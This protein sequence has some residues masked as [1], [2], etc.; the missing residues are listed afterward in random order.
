MASAFLKRK[1]WYLQYIDENGKRR[2]AASKAQTKREAR[3]LAD[4]LEIAYER[5]RFGLAPAR[6]PASKE[7]LAE[8]ATWW[9][10]TYAA[11]T[12]SHAID[13]SVVNKHLVGSRFG[14]TKVHLVTPSLVENFLQKKAGVLSPRSINHLRGYLSRIFNAAAKAGRY[15]GANPTK[16]VAKRR[17]AKALPNFLREHEVRPVL[18]AVPDKWRPLFAVAVYT[19]LRKGEI[20][21]L[22]KRDVDLEERQLMVARSYK[23]ETTKGGHADVIPLAQ[24]VVPYFAEA[25]R[26]S[27]STLVFPDE[28]GAMLSR[29]APLEEVLRRALKHA[30]LVEGYE[31]RCRKPGCGHKEQ[32]DDAGLRRCPEHDIKLW[33]VAEVR[34]IRFHDLRHTTA[35][36]LMMRGAN[37]AAVQRILRHSDPKITTEVYGHLVP[38]FMRSEIDRLTFEGPAVAV[39]DEVRVQQTLAALGWFTTR[40]LPDGRDEAVAAMGGDQN[41]IENSGDKMVGAKGF[42]PSASWSRTKRSTKLSYTPCYKRS[43]RLPQTRAPVNGDQ[44][45]STRGLSRKMRAAKRAYVVPL[46]RASGCWPS[47][48]MKRPPT[49]TSRSARLSLENIRVDRR[50][51]SSAPTTLGSCKSRVMKSAHLPARSSPVSTPRAAAP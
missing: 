47:V 34:R 30:G 44:A 42:E 21:G 40:L 48:T 22:R 9:L 8:L 5:Q 20:L 27:K 41:A 2:Q 16:S 15:T 33:P 7:I 35:S 36:L 13:A 43:P 12:A 10:Q 19:G 32:A 18:E 38:E 3:R 1:T 26:R 46:S 50:P 11:N 17:V 29:H 45:A 51:W 4:E 37:P 23:R 14:D 31:H 39:R 28:G 25:M 24:E 6:A 49:I